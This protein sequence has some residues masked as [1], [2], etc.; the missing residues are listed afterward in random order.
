MNKLLSGLMTFLAI[1]LILLG[2]IFIIAGGLENVAI[3]AAMVLVAV[4]L[5]FYL[6]RMAKIEA[7]KPKLINQ[8]FN[9]QMSGSG[10]L[11]QKQLTCRQC[12]A[13][14]EDKDLRV[15]QG[16][17]MVV[18]TG[19]ILYVLLSYIV[20]SKLVVKPSR[21]VSLKDIK[22]DLRSS[23]P[24]AINVALVSTLYSINGFLLLSIVGGLDG[25]DAGQAASNT[26]IVAFNLVAALIAVPTVFRTALLPVIARLFGSS[27][28]MTKLA[29]QKIMKYMRTCPAR[30]MTT[31]ALPEGISK[32]RRGRKSAASC[33][34]E[35]R[36]TP[37]S[38][39]IT[40]M[41]S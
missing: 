37:I 41:L 9:V 3:G 18:L 8:T 15:V 6:Y 14:L 12:G 34:A 4:G 30:W 1:F 2:G 7:A 22:A 24:F 35:I 23:A 40:G 27:K 26:F 13:P 19:S 5:F 33:R 39:P 17:V 36:K 29:Q 20:C 28:E 25:F 38:S 21:K 16:G 10:K 31:R 32:Y 11:E